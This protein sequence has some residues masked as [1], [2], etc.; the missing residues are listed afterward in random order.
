MNPFEVFGITPGFLIDNALLRKQFLANQRHWHPD[1]FIND[2]VQ[3]GEALRQTAL[4]NEA[5]TLLSDLNSR[6]KTM[7]ILHGYP[8]NKANVLPADYLMQM[9]ELSDIIEEA[10]AG[11]KSAFDEAS[12]HLQALQSENE[13]ATL[14]LAQQ[15]DEKAAT[16]G[17]TDEVMNSMLLLYQQ[18][19]Y[20]SRLH[21]NLHGVKEL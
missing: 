5:Y 3:H 4:N 13:Q 2:P 21:K 17:Y 18:H 11:D 19:R 20:L 7:L 16:E 6:V 15:A 10:S 14:Q 9:M 1:F 12:G 8:E